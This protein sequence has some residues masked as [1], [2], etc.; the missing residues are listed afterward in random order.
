MKA[1]ALIAGSILPVLL[2]VKQRDDGA[3]QSFQEVS[4]RDW[5][6]QM[7][8]L[9]QMLNIYVSVNACIFICSPTSNLLTPKHRSEHQVATHSLLSI[10]KIAETDRDHSGGAYFHLAKLI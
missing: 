6:T 3:R 4:K 9:R 10:H 7:P 2:L 1:T 8:D 5:I